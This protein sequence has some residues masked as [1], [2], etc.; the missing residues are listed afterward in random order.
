MSIFS[1]I[2]QL[3]F[4]NKVINHH[5]LIQLIQGNFIL[6]DNSISDLHFKYYT[7]I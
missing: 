7:L 6:K 1:I 2:Y 5:D 3:I 4:K